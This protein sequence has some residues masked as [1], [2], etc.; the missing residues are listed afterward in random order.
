MEV[1]RIVIGAAIEV[2][3]SL[4]PGLLESAYQRCL[5]HELSLRSIHHQREAVLAVRYKGA[6]VDCGYRL[7]FLFP[8]R[9]VVETKS[10][11]TIGNLHR[12]QLLT[13]LKLARIRTGLIINFNVQQLTAGIV[14]M[15]AW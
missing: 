1:T 7:D 5:S 6:E 13:Y 10:V 14:R 2:H 4:G 9:L 8:G 11:S 3:R 12:A 15:R